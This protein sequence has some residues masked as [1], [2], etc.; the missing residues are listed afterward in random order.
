MNLYYFL[1]SPLYEFW[2][3]YYVR[4]AEYI[5]NRQKIAT[6]IIDRN[7]APNDFLRSFLPRELDIYQK[8]NHPNIIKVY[9]ILEIMHRVYI[10]MELAD[11]GDLLNLIKVNRG[12]ASFYIVLID[13]HWVFFF[14]K[15]VYLSNSVAKRMFRELCQAIKYLHNMQIAHRDL[16][17][18][19]ILLDKH[20]HIKLGDFGFARNCGRS[21]KSTHFI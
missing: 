18:E 13:H 5:I 17:C 7:K 1:L 19:N 6:K 11:G 8:I 3:L 10:F 21:I 4:I 14:K 12:L 9:D 16:K 15:Q 2:F 20:Y